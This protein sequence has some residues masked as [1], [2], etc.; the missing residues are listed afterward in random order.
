MAPRTLE[1]MLAS[2]E[3]IARQ[4]QA[5]AAEME[6]AARTGDHE[7]LQAVRAAFA[8]RA[9][10]EK[11]LADCIA[12]ARAAGISWAAIGTM[13]GTSGEAARQRYGRTKN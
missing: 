3:K 4:L 7:P 6:R 8:A 10:A 13:V 1:E 2:V 9:F 11:H 12:E 5:D